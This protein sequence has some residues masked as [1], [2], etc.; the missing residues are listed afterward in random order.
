MSYCL[1]NKGQWNAKSGP[2]VGDGKVAMWKKFTGRLVSKW[3]RTGRNWS[4]FAHTHT[5]ASP[6]VVTILY[7]GNS[8][9]KCLPITNGNCCL[10]RPSMFFPLHFFPGSFSSWITHTSLQGIV[11]QYT[12]LCVATSTQL[13]LSG[14]YDMSC[15]FRQSCL[16][17]S[18]AVMYLSRVLST[19]YYEVSRVSSFQCKC[20]YK[21]IWSIH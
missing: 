4:N 3:G 5:H 10:A 19:T 6:I 15:Q 1:K 20:R 7:Y 18:I 16:Q 14:S 11:V 21:C 13:Q 12:C 9:T 8:A 17:F 2:K